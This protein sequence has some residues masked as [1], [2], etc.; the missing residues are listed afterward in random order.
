MFAHLTT[1]S[2]SIS[3]LFL[4]H[5]LPTSVIVQLAWVLVVITMLLLNV[6][7][8]GRVKSI[9]SLWIRCLKLSTEQL[10]LPAQ[11]LLRRREAI[12]SLREVTGRRV[13]TL[14]SV[15]MIVLNGRMFVRQLHYKECVMLTYLQWHQPAVQVLLQVQQPA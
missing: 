15:V 10:F 13:F 9:S 5:N 8:S 14:I 1:L 3:I 11:T 6:A 4:T 7:S 12:N 2:T